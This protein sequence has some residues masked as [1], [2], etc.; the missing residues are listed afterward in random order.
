MKSSQN[1]T[2]VMVYSDCVPSK[3]DTHLKA[4]LRVL[5]FLTKAILTRPSHSFQE[6]RNRQCIKKDH[7]II[8]IPTNS[9]HYSNLTWKLTGGGGFLGSILTTLDST[10][11]G[12]R[13]L[14]FPTWFRWRHRKNVT[15]AR[16][17]P[18]LYIQVPNSKGRW[19]TFIR[20]STRASSCVLMES[21][22]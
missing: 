5:F 21:L 22:Q 13:K 20:W 18:Q 6:C 7:R 9:R 16:E 2:N 11:G 19:R 15:V 14:F 1:E 4:A 3:V 8:R 10:L 17:E 12:G